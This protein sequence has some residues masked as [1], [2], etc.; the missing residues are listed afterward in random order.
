M[1]QKI[2]NMC[3][4]LITAI[5]ISVAGTNMKLHA[6]PA[7]AS[8]SITRVQQAKS[9]WCWAAC[10]EMVSTK[11]KY[12]IKQNSIVTKIKGSE[13]NEGASDSEIT[14]ALKYAVNYSYQVDCYDPY[15]Y[16]KIQ[17]N[18]A[19]GLPIVMKMKWNSGGAHAL[20]INGYTSN[21]NLILIDPASNCG[22]GYYSYTALING[23]TIQSGTGKYVLNW[24]IE[25]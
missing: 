5:S 4:I 23:T 18:I 11:L 7:A 13:V 19:R 22:T 2:R 15:S 12:N 8:L 6:E 20:V 25:Y 24:I 1:R 10:A 14:N 16:S 3:I 9:N 17:N 21:Q